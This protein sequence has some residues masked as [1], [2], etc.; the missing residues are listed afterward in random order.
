MEN[1]EA[2]LSALW[3]IWGA[4][5]LAY[6]RDAYDDKMSKLYEIAKGAMVRAGQIKEVD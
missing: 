6:N 2:L 3:E 1:N 5:Q 4:V